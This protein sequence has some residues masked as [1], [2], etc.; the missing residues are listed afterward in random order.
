MRTFD[1]KY[2][3][4]IR[5]MASGD[6][7]QI[8]KAAQ[9]YTQAVNEPIRKAIFDCDIASNIFD[10]VDISDC[11]CNEYQMDFVQP[12]L[13][14]DYTAY[15]IPACGSHPRTY[16]ESDHLTVPTYRIGNQVEWCEEHVRNSN[17]SAMERLMRIYQGGFV[18]KLNLDAWHL[19]ITAGL[20][21]NVVPYDP[22]ALTGNF[23]KRLLTLLK[24][25]FKRNSGGNSTCTDAHRLTDLFLSLEGMED[26]LNWQED[27]VAGETRHTIFMTENG[28]SVVHGVRMHELHELG[29]GQEYQVYYTSDLSGT[30]PTS[31]NSDITDA[32]N[33]KVE[34]VV[35]LSLVSREDSFVM[36]VKT[37]LQTRSYVCDR[38]GLAGMRGFMEHGLAVTDAR[39]VMLGAF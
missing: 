31:A 36:P 23:T 34:I 19:L 27:Q 30:L 15:A 13:E 18:R 25:A 37:P 29:V 28:P 2:K 6:H 39:A 20:N 5:M 16:F 38:D 35:G 8:A 7:A 3:E 33:D 1:E 21:R 22:D 11:G 10:A 12:G 9:L 14:R 17:F 4:A 32:A 26:V 24:L